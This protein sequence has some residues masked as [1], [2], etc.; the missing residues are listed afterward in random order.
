MSRKELVQLKYM[1][2]ITGEGTNNF[3]IEY[4]EECKD[5]D[6]ITIPYV[7]ND[8]LVKSLVEKNYKNR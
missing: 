8:D 7:A 2:I 6:H 5:T 1:T 3:I 4:N